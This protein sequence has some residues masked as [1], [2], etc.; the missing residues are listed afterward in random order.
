MPT[1]TSFG[2]TRELAGARSPTPSAPYGAHGPRP[3]KDAEVMKRDMEEEEEPIKMGFWVRTI[4]WMCFYYHG[5]DHPT[6]WVSCLEILDVLGWV[7]QWLPACLGVSW[8][9][10]VQPT[11]IGDLQTG[12]PDR[13]LLVCLMFLVFMQYT[14]TI[15]NV[16]IN[17]I[18]NHII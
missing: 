11:T 4:R 6:I 8:L 7:V 1:Q 16:T 10:V 13:M 5:L 14:V 18:D 17:N 2:R 15:Y 3:G 9:E 12:H